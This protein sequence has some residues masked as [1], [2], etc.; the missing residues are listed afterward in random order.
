MYCNNVNTAP[1]VYDAKPA[2]HTYIHT[3]I[4]DRLNTKKIQRN[5]PKEHSRILPRAFLFSWCADRSGAINLALH[6][7][8]QK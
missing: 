4:Q 2:P 5:I 6:R 7:N 3:Y 8:S 1:A